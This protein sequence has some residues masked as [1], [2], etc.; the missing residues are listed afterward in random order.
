MIEEK[1]DNDDLE[2]STQSINSKEE[3]ALFLERLRIDY[4]TNEDEWEN[5]SLPEYFHGMI[6][7]CMQADNYY[8]NIGVDFDC[9]QPSWRLFA[10]I[11]LAARV[12]E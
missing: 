3:F 2:E 11:L 10:D 4:Q 1:D 6:G 9:E 12:Y 5:T 7:F 8:Q